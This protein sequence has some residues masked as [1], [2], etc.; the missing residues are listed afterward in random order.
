MSNLWATK[1]MAFGLILLIFI[2]WISDIPI[3]YYQFRRMCEKEGGLKVYEKLDKDVGWSVEYDVQAELPA[4]FNHIAFVRAA[5]FNTGKLL[6]IRYLGG[7]ESFSRYEKRPAD[8][9]KSVKYQINEKVVHVPNSI[10]LIR[11]DKNIIDLTKKKIVAQ[12]T[13]FNFG[14]SN[15][16]NTLFGQSGS[17][18]CPEPSRETWGSFDSIAFGE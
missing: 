3:G 9:S 13:E 6:D 2:W 11:Y 10:R 1:K 5:D 15:P 14:W 4:S 12:F 7:K 8:M 16:D 17:A 18:I